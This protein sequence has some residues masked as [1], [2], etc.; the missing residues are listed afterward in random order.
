MDETKRRSGHS[1]VLWV[2]V[3]LALYPLGM[4]PIVY[5]SGLAIDAG[6]NVQTVNGVLVILQM[7]LLPIYALEPAGNVLDDYLSFCAGL[8]NSR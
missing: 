6:A 2:I 8:S 4:G 3:V 5:L 1:W 7:P